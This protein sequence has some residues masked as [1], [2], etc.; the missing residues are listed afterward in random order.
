MDVSLLLLALLAGCNPGG[1]TDDT[2]GADDT[3]SECTVH[4]VATDI[5][6]TL[7]T[8]DY[9]WVQQLIQ[10]THDCAMRPDANTLMQDYD[11]KGYVVAYITARGQSLSL[12]DGRSAAEA[13]RD[14]LD[15]H[16]FPVQDGMVFLAEG[17]G[18]LGDDAIAYKAGVMADL[19]ADGVVFDYAYGN[20]DTDILAFQEA[21]VP[22][23]QIFLVGDLAGTMG[24][25]G[26]SNDDAYTAH[27]A[28]H[29]AG[30]PDVS[31][32]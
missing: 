26:I 22:D 24:V 8:S 5:D 17:M 9:E 13:T 21:G 6:E 3:G 27:I 28:A 14:W 30:V 7:T 19:Q 10:P 18:A 4:A 23:A 20:A 16:D 12:S 29:M 1:D 15:A 2:S 32:P 11:A 25:T 31:C